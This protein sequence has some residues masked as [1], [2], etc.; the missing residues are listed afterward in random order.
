MKQRIITAVI[1]LIILLI[2]ISF[3]ETPA[4]NIIIALISALAVFELLHSTKYITNRFVLCLCILFS[5]IYPLLHFKAFDTHILL[6]GMLFLVT[7]GFSYLIWHETLMLPTICAAFLVSLII[8]VVFSVSIIIRDRFYPDGLFFYLLALS[9]GWLTD[10]GAYFVGVFFGKHKMAP[11]ISPHKTIEGAIGGIITTIL[12]YL[13]IG[14]LY[15]LY[16]HSV[17]DRVTIAYPVLAVSALI[18]G[19]AA[20]LG[21]LFAS[22]IKRQTGIKDYG[23]IFPG[24]GGVMDRFD[25]VLFVSPIIY[26]II[27]FFPIITRG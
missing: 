26:A 22:I 10:S 11:K 14:L 4:F 7:L 6:V 25:S 1:S 23:N 12:G 17:G 9:G 13:L 19:L 21:D 8:P 27:S 2:A 20:I 24:H 5:F 18:C 16:L 15:S 3:F